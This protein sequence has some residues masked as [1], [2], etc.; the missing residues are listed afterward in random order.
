MLLGYENVTHTVMR[1]VRR[2]NTCDE[3]HDVPITN[4]TMRLLVIYHAD[5]PPPSTSTAFGAMILP[6]TRATDA[7]LSIR[8]VVPLQ[9]AGRPMGGPHSGPSAT[10]GVHHIELRNE[11]LPL[12]VHLLGESLE[13]CRLFELNQFSRKHHMIR[14]EPVF[15]TEHGH[16]QLDALVLFECQGTDARLEQVRDNGGGLGRMCAEFRQTKGVVC[17][18]V[19][20]SWTRGSEVS[21]VF[22][23]IHASLF[24]R[25]L[26]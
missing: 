10:S 17:E 24:A 21:L 8:A 13:W 7:R 11:E 12:P 6:G 15:G 20:A 3:P 4:D 9:L 16:R 22:S 1:F 19:V 5:D 26:R 23:P 2:L 25:T 18:A 14:Y